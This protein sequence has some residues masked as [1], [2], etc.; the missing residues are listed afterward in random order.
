MLQEKVVE[1]LAWL[2]VH[3]HSS[4]ICKAYFLSLVFTV[5]CVKLLIA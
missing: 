2:L 3:K 4:A 5:L 1:I